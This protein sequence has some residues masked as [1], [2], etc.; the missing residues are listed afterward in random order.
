VS[1]L[2]NNNSVEYH[3]NLTFEPLKVHS[4]SS[5]QYSIRYVLFE[6][7]NRTILRMM[8][9]CNGFTTP[10]I[11]HVALSTT[12]DT[13]SGRLNAQYIS[14]MSSSY[15]TIV[16]RIEPQLPPYVAYEQYHIVELSTALG[17]LPVE[18]FIGKLLIL[19]ENITSIEDT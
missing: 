12:Q 14:N 5:Q 1:Y 8:T 13:V 9:R 17:P 7:S 18:R 3:Y 19:I 10:G 16:A 15:A 6:S 2:E 4:N 11:R